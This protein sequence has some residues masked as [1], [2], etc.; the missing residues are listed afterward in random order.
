MGVGLQALAISGLEGAQF[1]GLGLTG[2]DREG[3]VEEKIPNF[4]AA[5][6]A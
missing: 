3:F 1:R 2:I 6:A 4:L 5:R